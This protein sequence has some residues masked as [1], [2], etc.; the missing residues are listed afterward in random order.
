MTWNFLLAVLYFGER[1]KIEA[2]IGR[3]LKTEIVNHRFLI[4]SSLATINLYEL[5]SSRLADASSRYSVTSQKEVL[6][7]VR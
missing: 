7:D 5:T 6:D 1:A 3:F 4:G 2:L